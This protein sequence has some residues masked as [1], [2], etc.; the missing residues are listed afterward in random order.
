MDVS[1]SL[2]DA[3]IANQDSVSSQSRMEE[4]SP[5][6]RASQTS[7]SV[8]EPRKLPRIAECDDLSILHAI[9]V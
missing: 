1:D 7:Y 4:A 5:S 6:C 9:M 8:G 3:Q 2:R